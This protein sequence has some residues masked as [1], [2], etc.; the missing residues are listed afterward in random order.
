MAAQYERIQLDSFIT[1]HSGAGVDIDEKTGNICVISD[2]GLFLY[3]NKNGNYTK[4][5]QIA[6]LTCWEGAAGVSINDNTGAIAAVHEGGLNLYEPSGNGFKE[7]I[8]DKFTKRRTGADCAFRMATGDIIMVSDAEGLTLQQKTSTG[9]VKNPIDKFGAWRPGAGLDINQKN[10]DIFAVANHKGG[11]EGP[12]PIDADSPPGDQWPKGD[13][14]ARYRPIG[15]NQYLKMIVHH[16]VSWLGGADLDVNDETGEVIT[17]SDPAINMYKPEGDTYSRTSLGV[18][19][20]HSEGA[21]LKVN[22]Q[23][24]EF[25]MITDGLIQIY[26]TGHQGTPIDTAMTRNS[27]VDVDI[28]RHTGEIVLVDNRGLT[29]YRK[30]A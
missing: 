9:Y 20:T 19:H 17:V 8:L 10:G 30:K 24:G 14:L 6:P 18:A 1:W 23:T 13:C 11:A 25:V 26:V 27:G 7:C 15:S 29:L 16:P 22:A 4:Q 2:A 5:P 28:N 3:V 12:Y 21:A